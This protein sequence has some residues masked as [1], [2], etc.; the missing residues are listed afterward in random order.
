M[1]KTNSYEKDIEKAAKYIAKMDS[2]LLHRDGEN[3][4]ISDGHFLVKIQDCLYNTFFRPVSSRFIPLADGDRAGV[5]NNKKALPELNPKGANLQKCAPCVYESGYVEAVK[6]P[7]KAESRDGK[8]LNIFETGDELTYINSEYWQALQCLFTSDIYSKG[9][10][11]GIASNFDDMTA[12]FILPVNYQ[13]A[14]RFEIVNTEKL[15]MR[16]Y[17]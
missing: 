12:A 7:F 6:V 1:R 17:A 13:A 15:D 4:Y 9:R 3:V 10:K 16:K 5:Q 2:L 14:S 8:D 11:F